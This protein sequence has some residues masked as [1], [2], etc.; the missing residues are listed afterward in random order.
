MSMS[1][2]LHGVSKAEAQTLSV[3]SG[4][5]R[6]YDDQ[7]DSISVFMTPVAAET[8][9]TVFNGLLAAEAAVSASTVASN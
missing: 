8:M 3:D 4:V 7:G 5:L 6:F 2:N 1:R 9:A